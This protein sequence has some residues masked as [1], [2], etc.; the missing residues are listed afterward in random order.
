MTKRFW[1]LEETDGRGIVLFRIY[2]KVQE[3]FLH[4]ADLTL[5][6]TH[7]DDYAFSEAQNL[8]YVAEKYNI[9]VD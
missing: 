9:S 8:N 7:D 2:D 3:D 6:G 1:V 4:N 5:F